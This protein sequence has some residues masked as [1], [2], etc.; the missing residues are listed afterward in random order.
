MTLP[1]I[2]YDLEIDLAEF[3]ARLKILSRFRRSR[4]TFEIMEV[5]SRRHAETIRRVPMEGAM[6]VGLSFNAL[7]GIQTRIKE[8]L[9]EE[10]LKEENL[11]IV[12]EK[13]AAGEEA[14]GKAYLAAA[15]LLRESVPGAE[16]LAAEIERLGRE[17]FGHRDQ[18]L[19]VR[20]KNMRAT[21]EETEATT[22]QEAKHEPSLEPGEEN[23]P[24]AMRFVKHLG[25]DVAM[26]KEAMTAVSNARARAVAEIV[27]IGARHGYR[28]TVQEYEKACADEMSDESRSGDPLFPR[29][30]PL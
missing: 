4:E 7:S 24:P 12:M 15:R 26:R 22:V 6:P 23:L 11:V 9:Y 14:I 18:I 19:A 28:F 8:S 25:R 20:E 27:Q 29:L 2:I 16:A 5:H 17:E 3:Y 1:D 30:V 13:L 21:L 10:V